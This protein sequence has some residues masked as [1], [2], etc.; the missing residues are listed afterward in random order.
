MLKISF[1]PIFPWE[2]R[3]LYSPFLK[4]LR[5]NHLKMKH[6]VHRT[7]LKIHLKYLQLKKKM[8]MFNFL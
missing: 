5:M 8:K 4:Y 3:S 7:V 6:Q 1:S 2:K